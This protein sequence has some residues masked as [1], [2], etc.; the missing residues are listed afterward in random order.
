MTDN[1]IKKIKSNQMYF[2]FTQQTIAVS[3]IKRIDEPMKNMNETKTIR[4]V[5]VCVFVRD[6]LPVCECVYCFC[7]RCA[8]C[9]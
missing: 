2:L 6:S 5:C 1:S 7:C 4:R 8:K 9:S 3:F